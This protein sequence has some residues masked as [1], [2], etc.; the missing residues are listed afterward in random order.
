MTNTALTNTQVRFFNSIQVRILLWTL[1]LGLIP[2]ILVGLLAYTNS[3]TALSTAVEDNLFST[4]EIKA[5]RVEGRLERW[6]GI[7]EIAVNLPDITG[8]AGAGTG[9]ETLQRLRDDRENAAAYQAAYRDARDELIATRAPFSD[10]IDAIGII[11]MDGI[12]QVVEGT[13]TIVEG[14][15]VSSS[16]AF[17][18]GQIAPYIS[19]VLRTD[20]G[21][22]AYRVYRPIIGSNGRTIG[23][24]ALLVNIVGL[25]NIMDDRTGLGDTGETYII[26][27][28]SGQFLTQPMFT[29]EDV[30]LRSDAR[31]DLDVLKRSTEG[32]SRTA[33]GSYDDYRGLPV[34]G[35]WRYLPDLDWYMLGEQDQAEA[36]GPINDLAGFIV[37][38][39]TVAFIATT[40]VSYLVARSIARPLTRVTDAAIRIANGQLDERVSVNASSEVGV[41]AAAFNGMADNIQRL[42]D[43][44]RES[45]QYLERTVTDYM[46]FVERVS[47]GNL[48]TRLQL[49][50]AN[51]LHQREDA[52]DDDLYML[53]VN[54]NSMVANLAQMAEQV[55][56][57]SASISA[58]AAEIQ[59][60]TTQQTATATEQDAAVTQTV[61][62]VEEVRTTVQQTAERAQSVADA[63]KQSVDVSR[64]GQE[65]VADTVEG[66]RLIRQRVESIA[67]NILMLSERTQ[68]IGEIIDTVN[69]LADQSK[70][71][72][73]NASIE[74]ARA[75]EEGRG[76]AVV[77]ME[78][79]Q[80]AEQSR[81]ATA[82]VRDILNEIQQATNTAVMVTEEG[83]KGA[84]GG[85]QLVERAGEA[86]RNL[87]S[88]IEDAAQ[89]AMQIAASTHQQTNGM[90]Q[91]A[92]AMT[93]IKQ[94][95]AQTAASTKQTEQS[96]RDLTNMARSLEQA[97]DRYEL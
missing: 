31:V 36:F 87:A 16:E 21:V 8:E 44:E 94:A 37:F 45:K 61:A 76:F 20:D 7:L 65:A 18:E 54:L 2:V 39:V 62:T 78:V 51:G 90:D 77:A 40:V 53:G 72:A 84:E 22:L 30:V 6:Q 50:A 38:V 17:I 55:R 73:L 4:V 46:N 59:A 74:A 41:L 24:G 71:L 10:A 14:Q 89:A 69:A 95:T 57:A 32:D 34:I 92:G 12:V 88:T 91:L 5:Q 79:R 15:D 1:A 81:D 83:S 28:R 52:V 42:V 70:L 56:E 48:K 75:G 85:M 80:L 97:A 86:I 93:Q 27:G 68:Q 64:S 29:A 33:A 35:A 43:S 11:S 60:A 58:A 66:M 25:Q 9:I 67:E 96:V 3:Q 82:R 49:D 13:A 47:Q 23:V 19:P 26:D 63:S